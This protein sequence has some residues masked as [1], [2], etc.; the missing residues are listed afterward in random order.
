MKTGKVSEPILMRSVLKQ[1][2]KRREDIL[3]GPKIGAQQG[4]LDVATKENLVVST[5]PFIGTKKEVGQFGIMEA[6]YRM[7]VTGVEPIGVTISILL[8]DKMEEKALKIMME[9]F[10]LVCNEWN[11]DIVNGHTEV[12]KAVNE[13]IVTATAIGTSEQQVSGQCLQVGQELVVVGFCG[14]SGSVRLA[15][16]KEKELLERYS[17]SFIEDCQ[18]LKEFIWIKK[19]IEILREKECSVYHIGKGGVFGALW[20]FSEGS[21]VG[22]SVDLMKIPLKQETIEI[23]EFFNLNPYYLESIGCL[24]V[25]CTNG[26]ELVEEMRKN[27]ISATIIGRVTKEQSRVIYHDDE[28]R[29]LEQSKADEINKILEMEW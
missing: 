15:Y 25:G 16:R 11:I 29:Y 13:P 1:L 14:L 27:G 3:Q 18:K 28:E 20:K 23:S 7:A 2:K 24:L 10:R 5:T 19:G 4:I 8:P 22:F 12:T 17:H 6:L 9:E 21:N 26:N